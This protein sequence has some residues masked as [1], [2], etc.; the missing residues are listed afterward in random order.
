[1]KRSR[2]MNVTI[3]MVAIGALLVAAGIGYSQQNVPA[4]STGNQQAQQ[5]PAVNGQSAGIANF[6]GYGGGAPAGTCCQAGQ[7]M[8]GQ[9]GGCPLGG[10]SGCCRGMQGQTGAQQAAPCCVQPK[11]GQ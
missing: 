8:M 10:A 3:V 5:Q 4:N 9:G 7:C 11:Q 6:L 1:V 2:M